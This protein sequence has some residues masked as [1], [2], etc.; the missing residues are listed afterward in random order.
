MNATKT[1]WTV[2]DV[3]IEDVVAVS[4]NTPF[5]QLVDLRWIPTSRTLVLIST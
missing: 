2:G 5:K 1:V 4:P 3:M